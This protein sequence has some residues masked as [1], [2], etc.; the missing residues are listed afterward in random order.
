[1]IIALH[2]KTLTVKVDFDKAAPAG[3]QVF[4]ERHRHRPQKLIGVR[5]KANSLTQIEQKK[6]VGLSLLAPGHVA[7]GHIDSDQ[8]AAIIVYGIVAA[9]TKSRLLVSRKRTPLH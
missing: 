4:A 9:D 8:L 1:M 7:H 2:G 6:R 5:R 3:F